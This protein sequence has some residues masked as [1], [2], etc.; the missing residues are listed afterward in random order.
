MVSDGERKK[1]LFFSIQQLFSK[2]SVL[3]VLT[4]ATKNSNIST[5][6]F[7][8]RVAVPP[9]CFVDR[10]PTAVQCF[11]CNELEYIGSCRNCGNATYQRAT[12]PIGSRVCSPSNVAK[13]DPGAREKCGTDNP[14]ATRFGQLYANGFCLIATAML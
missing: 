11:R 14:M 9:S 12:I 4:M 7:G 1:S 5:S 3:K 13:T 6:T 10:H 8:P 2:S